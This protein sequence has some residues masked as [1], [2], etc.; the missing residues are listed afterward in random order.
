MIL[1]DQT[2]MGGL[3]GLADQNA[4]SSCQ[5]D[6]SIDL[7]SMNATIISTNKCNIFYLRA[8]G[9]RSDYYGTVNVTKSYSSVGNF[10]LT[11]NYNNSNNTLLSVSTTI[12]VNG[13][14]IYFNLIDFLMS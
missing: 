6:Y 13:I 2:M 11:A 8:I 3:V 1:L 4:S 9:I 12:E 7:S 5:S 10:A 14:K